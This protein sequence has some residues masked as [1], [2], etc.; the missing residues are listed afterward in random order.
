M[1]TVGEILE[2][3]GGQYHE[4][5]VNYRPGNCK[6]SDG[7]VYLFSSYIDD[8]PDYRYDIAQK[9]LPVGSYE[10]MDQDKYIAE[11]QDGVYDGE[12][13]MA[14]MFGV[15]DEVFRIL[16][17]WVSDEGFKHVHPIR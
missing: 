1:K 11:F 17:I 10:L 4:Y 7:L 13:S 6:G 2:D 14:N 12:I 9:S 5:E 15:E 16:V 3:L 8:N